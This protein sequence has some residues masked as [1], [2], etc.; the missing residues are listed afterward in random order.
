MRLICYQFQRLVIKN[1]NEL[2]F[3]RNQTGKQNRDR[4]GPSLS[5]DLGEVDADESG[6]KRLL[7][8]V[9]LA[10]IQS[11]FPRLSRTS[12]IGRFH[13]KKLVNCTVAI[14]PFLDDQ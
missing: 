7:L 2:K 1:S 11:D 10:K 3:Q 8:E 5:L 4:I 13:R 12:G 14:W 9:S 6:R